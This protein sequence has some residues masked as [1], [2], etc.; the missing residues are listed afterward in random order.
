M[1]EEKR[2]ADGDI[3]TVQVYGAVMEGKK[4]DRLDLDWE[5]EIFGEG[6]FGIF[7]GEILRF[8]RLGFG[9]GGFWR[10]GEKFFFSTK[11]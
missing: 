4:I 7:V 2:E 5:I 1:R 11:N 10:E 8:F 6:F 3:G 9:L